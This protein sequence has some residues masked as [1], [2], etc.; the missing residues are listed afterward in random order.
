MNIPAFDPRKVLGRNICDMSRQELCE[1][2]SRLCVRIMAEV[3]TRGR[4]GG[5]YPAN[6]SLSDNGEIGIGPSGKAPWTG[7]ELNFVAPEL[8]WNGQTGAPAD[9]YSVGL[10]L[11]YA[12][13]GGRLPYEGT[14]KDP[15]LRR[16]GGEDLTAPKNSGRRLGEVITRC[17]KFKAAERFQTLE[18]LRVVL[19]SCVKN[20][21]LSGATSAEAIFKKSDDELSEVERMMVNIIETPEPEEAPESVES[22]QEDEGEVRLYAPAGKLPTRPSENNPLKAVKTASGAAPK[23]NRDEP[24]RPVQPARQPGRKPSPGAVENATEREK[25]IAEEVK[26]RRR[27]PLVLIL[28]LCALLVIVALIFNSMLKDFQEASQIPDNGFS[29]I[30]ADPFASTMAPQAVPA[31][32]T[33]PAESGTEEDMPEEIVEPTATPAAEHGYDIKTADVSWKE[34]RD[35]CVNNGGHLVVISDAEEFDNVVKMAEAEGLTKL[36]IGCHRIDGT[37]VWESSEEGFF[38]WGKGEPSAYDYN[39]DVPEDYVMLWKMNG[40]WVYNDNRNDP[41]G[42]YPDMYSGTMGYVCE[43]GD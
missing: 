42:D 20:L 5:V 2:A 14:C 26:R 37:L 32:P 15:Q 22:V 34:A 3:G 11:Y 23:I 8:Y 39:D 21:Y 33:A 35:E 9:V 31:I 24:L 25:K 18:E 10:V 43:Y 1:F 4:R 28:V 6:I 38:K 12:V 36:W 19:D 17:L 29:A 41:C 30:V 13:S 27:R 16:M 40:Q 7:D